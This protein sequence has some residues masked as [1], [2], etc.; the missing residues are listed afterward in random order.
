MTYDEM[1][2]LLKSGVDA[3]G[4][5]IDLDRLNCGRKTLITCGTKS[6]ALM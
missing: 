3:E 4:K 2:E 5:S 6:K 1:I